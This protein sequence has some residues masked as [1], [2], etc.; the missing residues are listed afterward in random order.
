[1]NLYHNYLWLNAS[2]LPLPSIGQT[3]EELEVHYRMLLLALGLETDLD[4]WLGFVVNEQVIG[5]MMNVQ[6]MT[7]DVMRHV[8]ETSDFLQMGREQETG[9]NQ[10]LHVPEIDCDDCYFEQETGDMT[11]W[12]VTGTQ[13]NGLEIALPGMDCD[14][15]AAAAAGKVGS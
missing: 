7:G 13:E 4:P 12:E 14:E 8:L 10:M 1:M 11:A 6:E 15:A 2:G 3:E 9:S 5:Y